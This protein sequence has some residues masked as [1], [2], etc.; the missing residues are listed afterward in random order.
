MTT[1]K[2]MRYDAR[3]ARIRG[4]AFALPASVDSIGAETLRT[5]NEQDTIVAP[6]GKIQEKIAR[7]MTH[8][9]TAGTNGTS[10]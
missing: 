6:S 2:N 9:I 7:G 1:K 8:S 5:T 4:G 3:I 10:E